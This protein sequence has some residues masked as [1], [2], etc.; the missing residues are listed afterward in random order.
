MNI[1]NSNP[2]SEERLNRLVKQAA[3]NVALNFQ[4]L[5]LMTEDW[6]YT[7]DQFVDPKERDHL[8]G[9]LYSINEN[10]GILHTTGNSDVID[11]LFL[12]D[13]DARDWY[14]EAIGEVHSAWENSDKAKE[15]NERLE[16]IVFRWKPELAEQAAKEP[17]PDELGDDAALTPSDRARLGEDDTE[18]SGG[19]S[20]IAGGK[21]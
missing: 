7:Q 14:D 15:N 13:L 8:V 12:C 9:L 10:L 1:L 3:T 11:T 21:H 17:I 18:E 6:V 20:A 5:R 19:L 2:S 16:K 4:R